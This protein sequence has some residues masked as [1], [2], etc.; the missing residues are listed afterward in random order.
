MRTWAGVEQKGRERACTDR[1]ACW[2][3]LEGLLAQPTKCSLPWPPRRE[4]RSSLSSAGSMS[5]RRSTRYTV[6]HRAAASVSSRPPCMPGWAHAGLNDFDFLHKAQMPCCNK[7]HTP[8][9]QSP[10]PDLQPPAW[11]PRKIGP[12]RTCRTK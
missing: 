3:Q 1:T 12:A 6:V 10:H 9:A 8:Y 5:S 7:L 4:H 2:L 11:S